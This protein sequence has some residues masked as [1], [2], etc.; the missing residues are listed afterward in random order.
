MIS[1]VLEGAYRFKKALLKAAP[2][3][4]DLARRLHLGG[5]GIERR[6]EFV[7]GEARHL[8]H[9]IVE[10]RL[11]AGGGVGELYL[12]KLHTYRD[13]SRDSGYRVAACL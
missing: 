5:E 2:H 8:C 7:K 4:H 6:R 12:V 11:E 9:H 3:A 10:G 13:F 1:A